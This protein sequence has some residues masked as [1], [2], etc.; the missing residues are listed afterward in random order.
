MHCLPVRFNMLTKKQGSPIAGYLLDA[1]GGTERGFQAY[2]PAIT[3]A[4]CMGL[5]A[6]GL[7]AFARFRKTRTIFAKV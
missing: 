7:V 6:A 1:Y 3:Y 4:G 2:R 5:G